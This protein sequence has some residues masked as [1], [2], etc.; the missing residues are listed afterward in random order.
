MKKKYTYLLLLV[1]TL[2]FSQ[3][4]SPASPYYSGMVWSQTG[5]TL[6]AS[7][8]DRLTTKHTNYISY[9]QVWNAAVAT[10]VD[11]TNTANV[12]LLYGWEA[13]VD[14]DLTNDLSRDK[15]NNGGN[16]GQWNREHVYAK[17]LG[18]PALDDAPP[19][20]AGEDAH[21]L[22]ACDVTRNNSR[23]S[24]KFVNATGNSRA[25][26]GGW[27]P[28][29]TWKGDVARM[30]MYMYLRYDTQCLPTGVGIGTANAIDANMLDLFLQWNA[31]DPVNAYEDL[32]NTYHGN[33]SNFYAQGNRNPFIDN[34]YLATRI[35]GGPAAENRW[36][37]IILATENFDL[38]AGVAV[39]PNP[40]NDNKININ[41]DVVLDEINLIN[42]NGQLIEMIKNP[43]MIDNNYIINNLPKGFYFLKLTSDNQSVVKK[44]VVN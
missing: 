3:A 29:D 8:A 5:T 43:V 2:S 27:Y 19:S 24:L 31:E 11:A 25:V 41:T 17:S 12:L 35:W 30:M 10:D 16:A 23:G 22:R 6:K 36:P 33:T 26:N 21:M 37:T 28:G 42:I 18:N 4:G 20:D 40:T 15:N 9:S 38:F 32:R 1:T 13:G 39:Y 7:L 34:P 44:I 14:A